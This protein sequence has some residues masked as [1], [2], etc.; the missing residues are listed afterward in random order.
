M[1]WVTRTGIRVNRA[2]TAWLVVARVQAHDG[3]IGFDALRAGLR[4]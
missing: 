4:R 1:M 2:A 3:A